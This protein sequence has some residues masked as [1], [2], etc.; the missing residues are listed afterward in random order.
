MPAGG[1]AAT[2]RPAR[3][4]AFAMQGLS[5]QKIASIVCTD[6]VVLLSDRFDPNGHLLRRLGVITAGTGAELTYD[7][8]QIQVAGQGTMVAEDYRPPEPNRAPRAATQP[9]EGLERPQQTKFR[10]DRS[11]RLTQKDRKVDLDGNVEMVHRSGQYVLAQGV[12]TPPW[13]ELKG[14][15]VTTLLC[16]QLRA[17]FS[18]PQAG[19]AATKPAGAGLEG[20]PRI[21]QPTQITAIGDVNL[22]DG[23]RQKR[24]IVGQQLEYTRDTDIVK[25][26]GYRGGQPKAEAVMSYKDLDTNKLQ[27]WRSP[28]IIWF[29]ATDRIVTEEGTGSGSR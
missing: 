10:W 1:L 29:R 2:S 24:T 22:V 16:D 17:F 14:G 26:R 3:R 20:G 27:E 12:N 7:P 9:A 15:R 21:G 25:V 23:L 11:M 19:A 5:G 6:D 28:L 13:P 18:E 4:P 8:N